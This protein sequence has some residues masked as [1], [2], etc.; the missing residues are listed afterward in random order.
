LTQKDYNNSHEITGTL[1][2][3]KLLLHKR[4]PYYVTTNYKRP[5]TPD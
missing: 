5:F 2:I 4:N 1:P 3:F